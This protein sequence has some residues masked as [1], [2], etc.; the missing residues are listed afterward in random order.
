MLNV[1]LDVH[2][3]TYLKD[4][5]SYSLGRFFP[6]LSVLFFYYYFLFMEVKVGNTI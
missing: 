6:S 5:P 2:S 3:F 1:S 4:I